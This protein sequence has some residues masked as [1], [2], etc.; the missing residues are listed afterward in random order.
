MIVRNVAFDAYIEACKEEGE[1]FK[2]EI[3]TEIRE[4]AQKGSAGCDIS[5]EGHSTYAIIYTIIGLFEAG[6]RVETV[7]HMIRIRW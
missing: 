5:F 2:K 6:Y 1:L 4:E 7:A 3:E